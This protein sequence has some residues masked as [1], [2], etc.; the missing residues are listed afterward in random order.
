MC[1]RYWYPPLFI[2]L[3]R[4]AGSKEGPGIAAA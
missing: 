4:F 1:I 2:A 3:F